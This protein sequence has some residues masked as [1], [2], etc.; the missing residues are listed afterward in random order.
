MAKKEPDP[1]V[2]PSVMARAAGWREQD[3]NAAREA[4][5]Y[6]QPVPSRQFLLDLLAEFSRPLSPA[7]LTRLLELDADERE[8]LDH[9]L[10]AMERDGQLVRDRRGAYGLTERMNLVR[11]RV[12]AHPNGFGF[13]LP[14]DGSDD[15]FLPPRQ[16]RTLMHGDRILASVV[17]V[18]ARGRR[19]GTLVEVLER[20][21]RRVVGRFFV[22]D[23]LAWVHPDDKRLP[24]DVLVNEPDRGEA[25]P[26]QMVVVELTSYPQKRQPA[27]GRIVEVLGDH[28][29]PGMEIDVAIRAH[30]L[31]V[32]WPEAVLA[33]AD[34]LPDTVPAMAK[35]DRVD[36]TGIPLVTI[37]GADARDFD[38]AVH[39][40]PTESG[41]RLRVAIADVSAYVVPGSA[42]DDEAFQ[43]GNSVYFPGRVV[44]MLPEA[45]SNGLCSLNPEVDRLC[46]VCEM[47]IGHDGKIGRAK[48][49]RGVM[50]SA[51]RLTYD[52]VY[53][54][55]WEGK[56]GK[57]QHEAPYWDSLQALAD[58]YRALASQRRRRGAIDFETVETRIEFGPG[59]KI[60]RI[61]PVER[62]DAHRLIEECMIAANIAAAR[63]LKRHRM[64]QLYRVHGG[65]D[66]EKLANLHT[67][68]GA[69]GLG[70]GG[71]ENPQ[72]ADFARLLETVADRPDAELIQTVLLR[73]LKQA[74]YLPDNNG[75]FGLALDAYAHFTS[76][77]RRY[78]DLLVHRAIVHRL[79]G[80]GPETFPYDHV[81]LVD[82]GAHCSMT[83]RRAD[84]ATRDAVAWLKCEYMLDRVGE[85]FDG[86]VSA[87]TSFGLFVE[88]E[89]IHVEGLVHVTALP[90]DYYRFDPAHHRLEGERSG[91][92][93]TLGTPVRVKL[94]AVNLDERKI[95]FELLDADGDDGK[96]RGGRTA[97]RRS[98]SGTAAKEKKREKKAGDKRKEK[99][100]GK[101]ARKGKRGKRR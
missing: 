82:A 13:L 81:R 16:M 40:E 24:Q 75:H 5:R 26:G 23:R 90:G 91:R 33:E 69:L 10:G 29:A 56:A 65:P 70:L 20:Q 51:A 35:A 99:E 45:L 64:P 12:S 101:G 48:F 86:L 63:Y 72:P 77:I 60:E 66:V 73:S 8:G 22:E 4:R 55:L 42:L 89:G 11:G 84:E 52:T 9:R 78:P 83:E 1:T 41:W 62:N 32:A 79:A 50:R 18:D 37:D 95:D 34:A 68:L 19:E 15:L 94:V 71:G 31:P 58:V 7:A 54:W 67:F 97:T 17:G 43:R 57:A 47:L 98:R 59:R 93:F 49:Q 25:A 85:S 76:P 61:V 96:G 38:D 36:L 14:E 6:G 92:R 30:E 2:D 39:A 100:K 3:P 28:M 53:G 27:V 74:V 88:L 80:G 21:H 87:V 44:P 46:V